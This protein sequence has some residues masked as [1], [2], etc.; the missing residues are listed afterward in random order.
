MQYDHKLINITE[1]DNDGTVTAKFANG[2]LATGT[3]LIGADSSRSYVRTHLFPDQDASP[4]PLDITMCNLTVAYHD[5]EKALFVRQAHPVFSFMNHPD[6]H[7]LISL[8]EVPDLTAPET[9]KFQLIP[10]WQGA[11]DMSL[12]NAERRAHL[13]ERTSGLAEPFH[14][15]YAW[16][17]EDL[18]IAYQHLGYWVA[19]EPWDTH[20]GRISLAGDAAH[21][22][23]PYRGQGLN[24]ALL[25]AYSL[26]QAIDQ[27]VKGDG[28][29]AAV[30]QK[31]SEEIAER[32]AKEVGLSVETALMSM[33]HEKIKS[34]A[35]FSQGFARE[36]TKV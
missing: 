22:M 21:P 17:P 4:T 36:E 26:V 2:V 30:I 33:D 24:N 29:Q 9:W 35:L 10:S 3:L 11:P 28:E 8:Y 34:S 31:A 19:E 16:I 20:S 6:V 23:P 15:A 5:A 7:A 25:D 14:S 12:S 27:M 13:L 1:N 32:G 18:E